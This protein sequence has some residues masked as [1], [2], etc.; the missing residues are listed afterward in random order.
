MLAKAAQTEVCATK[1]VAT[2]T[3]FG[4]SEEDGTGLTRTYL[5]NGGTV[6]TVDLRG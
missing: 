6:F 3:N 5:L 1:T 2:K 4:N